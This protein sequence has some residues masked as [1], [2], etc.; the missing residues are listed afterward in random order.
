MKCKGANLQRCLYIISVAI[1][2]VGLS[3]AVYLYLAAMNGSNADS[4]YEVV[5]G[6]IYPADG[7]SRKYTHDLQLY[8][9]KA[10]LLADD[11]MRW[12]DGLWHGKSLAFT[13]AVITI[14]LSFSF[15][16]VARLVP[17]RPESDSHRENNLDGAS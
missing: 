5:G 9:G 6:F 15:F 1:L 8:G 3:S 16:L 11:F 14:F 4:G 17:P 10:A 2:L 12:F 7:N 13:V